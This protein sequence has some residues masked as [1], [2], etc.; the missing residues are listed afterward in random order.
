VLPEPVEEDRGPKPPLAPGPQERW[1]R[2]IAVISEAAHRIVRYGPASGSAGGE[3]LHAGGTLRAEASGLPLEARVD[4]IW[5]RPDGAIEAVLVLEEP[6]E[7]GG[8]A[9]TAKDD[10]RCVLAAAIVSRLYGESPDL[11]T[12]WTAEGAARVDV[13]PAAAVERKLRA[14]GDSLAL[15]RGFE[16]LRLGGEPVLYSFDPW[17]SREIRRD[18]SRSRRS[19]KRRPR[20]S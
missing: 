16:G 13:L 5:R 12:V 14:L 10:W 3:V 11:H 4:L 7:D 17:P 18:G 9:Y 6:W 19:R 15:A 8:W 2:A 1:E 20:P